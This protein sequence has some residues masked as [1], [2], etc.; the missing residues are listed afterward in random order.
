MR[1]IPEFKFWYRSTKGFV[2]AFGL[3][4]FE[5]FNIPVSRPVLIIYF[6]MLL[7]QTAKRQVAHM[8]KYNYVP[9]SWGDPRAKKGA[10][11]AADEMA[12]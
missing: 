4:F 9:C 1:M 5:L 11:R 10:R 7:F 12:V 8:I 3:T 2:V 6:L